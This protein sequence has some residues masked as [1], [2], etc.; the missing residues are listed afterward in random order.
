VKRAGAFGAAAL[1]AILLTTVTAVG[2][3]QTVTTVGSSDVALDRR[4][5]RL[6]QDNPLIIASDT[7]LEA[8]DTILGPVLVLDATLILEGTIFGDLVGVEAG[9]WIR[10]P[11]FV[12]GDLVNIGGGLYRDRG[13]VGGTI[14]DLPDVGNYR[15]AREPDRIV[16]EASGTPSRVALDGPL[17]FRIPT[18]D[19]TNGL[20]A[21]WG[22]AYSLPL[23]SVVTPTVRGHGGWRT[24]LGMPVYGGSLEVR[25]GAT[26]FAGGYDRGWATRDA[27]IQGDLENSLNYLWDGSDVRNYHESERS[28]AA[29]SREFGDEAKSFFAVLRVVG[30]I[31]D[32][33]SLAASGPWTIVDRT[34]RPNPAVDDGRIASATA[35]LELEY[36]SHVADIV[37]HAE[38]EA[39]REEYE[40]EHRFDRI[41]AS[42]A[43]AVRGP[44][45]HTLEIEAFGQRPVSGDT[46]PRQRWSV[47]GGAGTLQTLMEGQYRGDRVLVVESTYRIPMGTALAFSTLGPPEIQLLHAAGLAWVADTDAPLIHEIGA[48]LL[49]SRAFARY[50][51]QPDDP[52]TGRVLV[53]LSLPLGSGYLWQN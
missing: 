43:L 33:S 41:A 4:L 42:V 15:V 8:R 26:T 21:A 9:L 13:R 47:A 20:T 44:W 40:G 1:A 35:R 22:A 19:R 29:V 51:F 16:I 31:E 5:D 37:G 28:W 49:F 2:A 18:Y 14:I 24:A 11:A 50:M 48:G 39:A 52:D 12:L 32:A 38:Y 53:G 17:G 25:V 46:L 36:H 10:D 6:L 30:Q 7:L 23:M 3:A 45:R 34:T 27:W